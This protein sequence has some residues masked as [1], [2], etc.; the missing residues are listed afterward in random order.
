MVLFRRRRWTTADHNYVMQICLTT[1]TLSVYR[2]TELT[3]IIQR[4]WGR[5]TLH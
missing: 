3:M 4:T 5:R 2:E 1:Y